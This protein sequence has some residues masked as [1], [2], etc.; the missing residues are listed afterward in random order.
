MNI[1]EVVMKGCSHSNMHR[2]TLSRSNVPIIICFSFI[3]CVM[4]LPVIG[5]WHKHCLFV[6]NVG[7]LPCV[8]V[9]YTQFTWNMSFRL[10]LC[11]NI[12]F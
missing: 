11:Y 4:V 7:F 8:V 9:W 6:L 10:M 2:L 5:G 12:P 3:A 1:S